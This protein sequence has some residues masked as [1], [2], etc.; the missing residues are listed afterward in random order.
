MAREIEIKLRVTSHDP[1]RRR[2][3][4]L[5]ATLGWRGVETNRIYDRFDGG[6]RKAGVGLRVRSVVSDDEIRLPVTMTVKGPRAPGVVKSRDEFETGVISADTVACMLRLLGFVRVLRYEKRREH[7]V[8]GKC[9]VELDEPPHI[10]LF[11]EIEGPD[12]ETIRAC[13][14]DIGLSGAADVSESYVRL[15]MTYC[16]VHGNDD[17]DVRLA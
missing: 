13:Q 7:W 17:H 4:E 10:G 6:L 1:V 5:G 16:R 15:M 3:R 14:A 11:V 9:A 12:E 8:L 2:L